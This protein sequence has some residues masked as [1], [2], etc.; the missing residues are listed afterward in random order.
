[1]HAP[2]TTF[3]L[4]SYGDIDFAKEVFDMKGYWDD[5]LNSQSFVNAIISKLGLSV[6]QPSFNTKPTF[7]PKFCIVNA[8]QENAQIY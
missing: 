3:H 8:P 1:M 6:A 2:P 5:K 7:I 4:E